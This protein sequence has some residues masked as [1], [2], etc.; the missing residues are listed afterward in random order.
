MLLDT[1][2]SLSMGCKIFTCQLSVYIVNCKFSTIDSYMKYWLLSAA[3]FFMFA[4]ISYLISEMYN[5]GLFSYSFFNRY[6]S[7][8]NYFHRLKPPCFHFVE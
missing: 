5:D 4:N 3:V 7:A 6:L 8:V 2:N 1:I